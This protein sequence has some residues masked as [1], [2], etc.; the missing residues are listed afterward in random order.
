MEVQDEY[1]RQFF[2]RLIAKRKEYI[3]K[4]LAKLYPE[5]EEKIERLKPVAFRHEELEPRVKE[6]WE[7]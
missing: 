5:K 6:S 4:Q 3:L 2:I 1:A 7:V